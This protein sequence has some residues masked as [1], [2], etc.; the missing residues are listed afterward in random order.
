[1]GM[2]MYLSYCVLFCL[3]IHTGTYS[4]VHTGR[5]LTVTVVIT[6]SSSSYPTVSSKYVCSRVKVKVSS[7]Y[8]SSKYAAG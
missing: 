4:T 6:S 1:M 5:Y 3:C 2:G 7:K 8:V